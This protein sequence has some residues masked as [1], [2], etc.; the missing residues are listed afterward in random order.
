MWSYYCGVNK[1]YI[2]SE[3][4]NTVY[5]PMVETGGKQKK[6]TYLRR[7]EG[8]FSIPNAF[9]DC[10]YSTGKFGFYIKGKIRSS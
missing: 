5:I 4:A 6:G 1:V 2:I 9:S 10:I 7:I 3:T 8:Q